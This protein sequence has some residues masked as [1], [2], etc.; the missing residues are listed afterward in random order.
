MPSPDTVCRC[1]SKAQQHHQQTDH[2]V[3]RPEATPHACHPLA[4]ISRQLAEHDHNGLIGASPRVSNSLGESCHFDAEIARRDAK[5]AVYFA[6]ADLF[7]TRDAFYDGVATLPDHLARIVDLDLHET[8]HWQVGAA[9]AAVV[10]DRDDKAMEVA[11][12]GIN[13]IL[14]CLEDGVI[15]AGVEGDDL[16][17]SY[18]RDRGPAAH[19][20]ALSGQ[21]VPF[22]E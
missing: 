11:L 17:N 9:T 16:S 15:L 8:C 6:V 5:A 21:Q 22:A 12:G 14:K 20:A 3:R 1:Q 19:A 4:A 13:A 10:D 18:R 7:G 2:Q